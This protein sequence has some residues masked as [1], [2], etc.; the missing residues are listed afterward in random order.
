MLQSQQQ[1][2]ALV[3]RLYPAGY[4]DGLAA[5]PDQPVVRLHSGNR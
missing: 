4:M 1:L 5:Q 3:E 2:M